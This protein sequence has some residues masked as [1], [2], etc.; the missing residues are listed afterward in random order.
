MLEKHGT[1]WAKYGIENEAIKKHQNIGNIIINTADGRICV[2]CSN[3]DCFASDPPD[4]S[5]GIIGDNNGNGEVDEDD[6]EIEWKDYLKKK[7]N[8]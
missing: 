8:E 7:M 2:K 5:D 3:Y 6:W 1:S 4:T